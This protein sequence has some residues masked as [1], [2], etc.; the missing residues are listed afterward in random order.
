[1][2]TSKRPVCTERT[3]TI[4][5]YDDIPQTGLL[6]DRQIYPFFGIGRSTWWKWVQQG[7]APAGIKLG[8]RTTVWRAEDI[9]ALLDELSS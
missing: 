3:T 1:M 2:T 4:P 5:L 6:R 8:S 9:R 7:K